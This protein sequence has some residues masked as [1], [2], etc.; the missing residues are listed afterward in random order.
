MTVTKPLKNQVLVTDDKL[1]IFN[2]YRLIV[3]DV[4]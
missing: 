3:L 2:N 4:F 1:E